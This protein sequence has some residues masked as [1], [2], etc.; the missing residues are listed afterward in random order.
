MMRSGKPEKDRTRPHRGWYVSLWVVQV[1]LAAAFL[2]AGFMKLTRPVEQLAAEMVWP[3]D[4][5][6]WLLRFIGLAELSASIGLIL[7]ALTR[8]RPILTPLAATG[9]TVIMVLAFVFHI[10]RG[11]YGA[12]PINAAFGVLAA[13]VAYGRFFKAPIRP[14]DQKPRDTNPPAPP[15]SPPPPGPTGSE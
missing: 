14:R 9:L 15:V 10:P 7:P 12:L 1:I 6:W 13:F 3:G 11:E 4:I 8:I 5:P 2:M